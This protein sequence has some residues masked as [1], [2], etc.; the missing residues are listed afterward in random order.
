[1]PLPLNSKMNVFEAKNMEMK[2]TKTKKLDH[3]EP[4]MNRRP[5]LKINSMGKDYSLDNSKEYEKPKK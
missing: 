5:V 2:Q 1:M 4:K 3:P